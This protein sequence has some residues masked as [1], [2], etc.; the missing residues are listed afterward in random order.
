MPKTLKSPVNTNMQTQPPTTTFWT[1]LSSINHH[2]IQIYIYIYIYIYIDPKIN[3]MVY[4]DDSHPSFSL[5]KKKK[6][7]KRKKKLLVELGKLFLK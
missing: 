6:K 3:R 1:P 7:R 2:L 4:K 5:K